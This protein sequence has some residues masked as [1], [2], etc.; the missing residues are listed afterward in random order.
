M[1][2]CGNVPLESSF[3]KVP[4]C[5]YTSTSL[6]EYRGWDSKAANPKHRRFTWGLRSAEVIA[7][8]CVIF[9]FQI[10]K[11]LSLINIQYLM[12]IGHGSELDIVLSDKMYFACVN[13][14]IISLYNSL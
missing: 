14:F 7:F 6:Y 12:C 1:V 9:S 8:I 4:R 3:Q 13:N 11:F 10:G 2:T 5:V